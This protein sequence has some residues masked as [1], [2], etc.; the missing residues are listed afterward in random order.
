MLAQEY[1]DEQTFDGHD[2]VLT[3]WHRPLHAMTEAFNVLD[4]RLDSKAVLVDPASAGCEELPVT[5]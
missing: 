5:F 4:R 2:V 1:S 3:H